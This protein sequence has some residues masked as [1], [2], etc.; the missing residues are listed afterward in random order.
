[1][2]FSGK[3]HS[4]LYFLQ[5]RVVK[6]KTAGISKTVRSRKMKFIFPLRLLTS[7]DLPLA[8]PYRWMKSMKTNLT[9]LKLRDFMTS[10]KVLR[11]LCR[12]T[13]TEKYLN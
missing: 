3:N 7:M 1:M 2:S 6:I 10:P 4:H 11:S 12:L 8:I 9:S 13:I 5:F